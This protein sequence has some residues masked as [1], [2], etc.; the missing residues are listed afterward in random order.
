MNEIF[1]YDMVGC[2]GII[3]YGRVLY[4]KDIELLWKLREE[5]QDN[6]NAHRAEQWRIRTK[7]MGVTCVT[8]TSKK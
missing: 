5:I 8:R 7:L 3:A 1:E 4:V 2:M 6:R